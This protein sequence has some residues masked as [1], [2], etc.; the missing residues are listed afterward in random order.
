[1]FKSDDQFTNGLSFVLSSRPTGS[2]ET[3]GGT[4][5][6]GKNLLGWALPE[7]S[8]LNYRESWVLGQTIQTPDNIDTQELLLND[9]PY[10]GMVGWGNSFYGFN[11][12]EFWGVQWLLGWV[13]E[14][15]LGEES[16]QVVH[17]VLGED[18]PDGWENQLDFEPLA[19][20]YFTT[21]HRFLDLDW[22]DLTATADLAL[23]NFFTYIQPGLELRFGDRPA[24]FTFLPDPIG[25]GIDY[26]AVTA[27]PGVNLYGSVTLRATQFA[28]AMPREGNLFVDNEWTDENNIDPER[29][30]AQAVIGLHWEGTNWG[31]HATVW[32]STDT[33]KE[34]DLEGSTD[35][36]NRFGSLMFERRF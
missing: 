12:K 27:S 31:A 25:R 5:A 36:E 19:N 16:Q 24:G 10:M 34:S 4:P 28:W 15:A 21:K 35:P 14:E 22:F 32:L 3:T 2:V 26:D 17:S 11:D 1:M 20:L 13:G 30:V 9:V 29:T 33:V 8:D 6:F 7:S 23:G 18:N